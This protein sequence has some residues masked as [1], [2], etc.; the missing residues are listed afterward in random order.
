[1]GHLNESILLHWKRKAS[2]PLER[3]NQEMHWKME[4]SEWPVT[5][6][7]SVKNGF[8]L[9]AIHVYILC[10]DHEAQEFDILGVELHYFNLEIEGGFA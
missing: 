1:M 5:R 2:F 4:Q 3:G 9:G 6:F 10:I 8:D 7:R